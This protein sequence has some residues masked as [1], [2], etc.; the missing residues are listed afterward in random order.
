MGL[1]TVE[2]VLRIEDEFKIKIRDEEAWQI[3]TVGQLIRH[4]QDA[5]LGPRPSIAC[6]S[7]ACFYAFRRVLV[8]ELGL[9]PVAVRPSVAVAALVPAVERR[10]VWDALDEA[11]LPVHR[12]QFLPTHWRRFV[13][14]VFWI[15]F[16]GVP[17]LLG[18]L[19]AWMFGVFSEWVGAGIVVT[20]ILLFM[21]LYARIEARLEPR[22]TRMKHPGITVRELIHQQVLPSWR[23]PARGNRAA[24]E[25]LIRD[26]V[27][28]IV[29]EELAVSLEKLRDG[30]Q[31][32]EDLG[33]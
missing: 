28:V 14:I 9:A 32:V 3:R 16:L 23:L 30:D 11:G 27:R 10:H 6:E 18:F 31:F 1:D 5:V 33:C 25:P 17:A 2:M 24:L 12:L 15:G 20:Q 21:L 26:R 19:Y 22:R 13:A 8:S 29:S 4:V 7:A